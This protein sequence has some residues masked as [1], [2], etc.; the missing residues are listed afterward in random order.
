MSVDIDLWLFSFTLTTWIAIGF[1]GQAMF[2]LRFIVQW[3]SSEKHRRSYIPMAFWYFS[4]AGG[5]ILLAYAIHRQDPVFIVGQAFG[6]FIYLR[7]LQLIFRE[8]KAA[9]AGG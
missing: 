9:T 5:S 7:N 2:S 4:L 8:R 3:L 1:V 6:V